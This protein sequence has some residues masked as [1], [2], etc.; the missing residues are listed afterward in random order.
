MKRN[1]EQFGEIGSCEFVK[2]WF[3]DTL[4]SLNQ[5]IAMAFID[6]DLVSSTRTCLKYIY[7]RLIKGGTI[8]SHDGL[9]Q[10][11]NEVFGD[12]KFWVDVVGFP[13]PPMPGLGTDKLL[14]ITKPFD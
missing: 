5:P 4:P 2:G 11:C 10:R 13:M 12:A 3:E 1:V 9:L 8:F 6:V 7:P 14:Q